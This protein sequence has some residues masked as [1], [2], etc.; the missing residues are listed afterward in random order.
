MPPDAVTRQPHKVLSRCHPADA[1][2]HPPVPVWDA[3]REVD[4]QLARAL[5]DEQFPHLDTSKLRLLG[6]GWDNTV[7]LTRDGIAFR[8]PRRAIAV[9]GIEREIALLPLLAP[10]LP[11]RVPD[12]AYPGRPTES[13]GW[14]WFG[15]RLIDGDELAA[16]KLD[17][18]ARI[19]LAPQ[20]AAALRSLHDQSLPQTESLPVDP[21]G[22][23]EMRSR[24]QR[25]REAV[26]AIASIWWAPPTVTEI[27]AEAEEL[28]PPASTTLVHGDLHARHVLVAGDGRLTGIIDWGDVCRAD[29]SADLSLVWSA[30]PPAGRT[31]FS[32]VY[33]DGELTPERLLR[34]RVIALFLC[35]TLADYARATGAP[36][37]E[38]EMIAGLGRTLIA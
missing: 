9:P 19:A 11:V 2:Q 31:A 3:E 21:F 29:P 13:Y 12:A 26:A 20:L 24:V 27:L 38:R 25:T 22:R 5:I 1:C 32:A 36:A 14:P 37:L 15:S 17:D 30:L 7:W 6:R 28:P 33:G 18:E 4:Q 8:F 16:R 34:A 10:R 23:T 35:A